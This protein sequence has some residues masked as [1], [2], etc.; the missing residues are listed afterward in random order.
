MTIWGKTE[1]LPEVYP[2]VGESKSQRSA[3]SDEEIEILRGQGTAEKQHRGQHRQQRAGWVLVS[4]V[5]LVSG[6]L[7]LTG[8]LVDHSL[9][10]ML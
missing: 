4:E 6:E 1:M 7:A 5:I 10:L 3:N 8:H 2:D 9:G